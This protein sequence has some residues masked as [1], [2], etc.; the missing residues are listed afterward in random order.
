VGAKIGAYTN[1][2]QLF[3]QVEKAFGIKL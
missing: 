2:K 1:K 3:E